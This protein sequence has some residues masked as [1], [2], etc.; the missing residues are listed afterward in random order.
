MKRSIAEIP[1]R[2]RVGGWCVTTLVLFM[3]LL[4]TRLLFFTPSQ[5]PDAARCVAVAHETTVSEPNLARVLSK[6]IQFRTI[7]Y[8][9]GMRDGAD[10]F[11]GLH[12]LLRTEF[13][14]VHQHLQ[15]ET[16]ANFSLLYRWEGSDP[17]LRPYLLASH[18]DVVPTPTETLSAW[19]VDP[20]SG[21]LRDGFVYGRGTIDDKCGV[22]ALLAAC[23]DL[24]TQGFHP[25]RTIYLAF[26]HDEEIG[27]KGALAIVNLLQKRDIRLEFVLDEGL[28]IMTEGM[29]G[30]SVPVALIGV[31]EKGAV[32]IELEVET[33]PG[34]SSMPPSEGAIGILAKAVRAL[35]E[36]PFPSSLEGVAG[37]LFEVLAPEMSFPW[38]LLFANRDLLSPLI[39]WGMER[40]P[41]QAAFVRTTTAL[42]VFQSG[43]KNN[44]IPS[45]ATAV[46]NHRLV[47][48]DSIAQ[49]LERDRRIINDPR[50]HI[51]LLEGWEPSKVTCHH[52]SGYKLIEYTNLQ[53]NSERFEEGMLIAPG[54]MIGATDSRIYEPITDQM[55]RHNPIRMNKAD[56]KRFHGINE[57]IAVE[58]LSALVRF[59]FHLIHNADFML[60]QESE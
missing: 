51:R 29:P 15:H 43:E 48:G 53:V 6:A 37:H 30:I 11:L 35:E 58:D 23:E 17:S 46:V 34:H 5:Q 2:R 19:D 1:L 55:Y 20:F 42:T 25:Q 12:R 4:F 56:T 21:E 38:N 45:R 60:P 40:Q 28:P 7:S 41:T 32:S 9:D 33:P 47:P 44:V 24:L 14:K 31:S 16:V 52:A 54:L 13:P 10:Q 27:G 22:I 59:F 49:V 18:L 26:G 8:D 36:N 3:A 57:R 50:V 39:L